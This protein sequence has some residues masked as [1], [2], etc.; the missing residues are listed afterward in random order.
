MNEPTDDREFSADEMLAAEYAL[1]VLDGEERA[2]AATRVAHERGFARIVADWEQ[3]LSPWAAEI[4]ETAPPPDMWDRIAAAL[5]AAPASN[6]GL[7][8]SLAFWRGLTFAT[9]AL[10]AVCLGALVY[11]G[12][13]QP[14][15]QQGPMVAAID[16]GGQRHFVAS[17]D[18]ARGSIAVMPASYA[19]DATRV[20]ELWVIPADGKPRPIGLLRADRMVTI[21]MPHDLMPMMTQKAVLAVSLEPQGGSPTGLP[22]GP[23]IG[24]GK[25][26]S[27]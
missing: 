25:F 10:A 7:W 19:A 15:P 22:T 14:T 8:Q 6:S 17:F 13:T 18:Q 5:P 3:R 27:L 20:P 21:L 2:A 1:G 4:T 11:L 26:A 24:T 9:G 16:G 23:V 12:T